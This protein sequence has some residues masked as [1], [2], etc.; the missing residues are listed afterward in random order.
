MQLHLEK[1]HPLVI[2]AAV[3]VIL[4]SAVAA[5][6]LTGL[7]PSAAS[8]KS[9]ALPARTA[10]APC[11][12]CGTVISVREVQVTTSGSGVG[13]VAGGLTGAVVGSQF[14]RGDGRTAM[15]ILGAAGG[16]YAGNSIEKNMHK[17]T[18]WR[19]TVRMDDETHRTVSQPE[20][21]AFAVGDKV[22]I[23][24]GHAQ[25]LPADARR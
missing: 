18:A 5:A 8:Q 2:G 12:N 6:A 21:P 3:S 17:S 10:A 14:G 23:V 22:R 11:D 13:A 1:T 25:P 24:E 4:C 15:T 7:I 16:A 20:P 19:V 9:D